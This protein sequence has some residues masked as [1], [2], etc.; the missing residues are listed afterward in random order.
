MKYTPQII[1]MTKVMLKVFPCFTQASISGTERMGLFWT[2]MDAATLDSKPELILATTVGS[3]L[4]RKLSLTHQAIQGAAGC[5]TL[6]CHCHIISSKEVRFHFCICQKLNRILS[7]T[8]VTF[9]S[10]PNALQ[11]NIGFIACLCSIIKASQR[12]QLPNFI[13]QP[14]IRMLGWKSLERPLLISIPLRNDFQL[15]YFKKIALSSLLWGRR[16]CALFSFF[17]G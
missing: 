5:L 11:T 14:Q 12:K 3:I 16:M 9:L 17:F 2:K 7:S 1:V 4:E 6:L 8:H 13:F 10:L 15:R